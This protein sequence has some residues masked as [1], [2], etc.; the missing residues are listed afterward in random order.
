MGEQHQTLNAPRQTVRRA[1]KLRKE[2]SLPE[3]LL[4]RELK[5]R[6]AGLK[7]RRQH[8]NNLIVCDF[9]CMSE[10]LI[11]EID[12]ESHNMGDR[13][14]RDEKRDAWLSDN[15]YRVLRIPARHVLNDINS[16]IDGIV[17]NCGKR[18]I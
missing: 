18:I 8:P 17:A 13:P 10:R 16:V 3:V 6:P 9:A 11:I 15:G 7:F 5:A 2:M 12:G 4:W 14:T 1:R